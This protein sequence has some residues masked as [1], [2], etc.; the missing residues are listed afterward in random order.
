MYAVWLFVRLPTA[1]VA[2]IGAVM[3]P[4]LEQGGYSRK[5][6]LS[7]IAAAGMLRHDYSAQHRDDHILLRNGCIGGQYVHGK[8]LFPASRW[9]H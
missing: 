4:A 1:T 8:E 7:T 6:A 5:F 9:V 2:A 3:V